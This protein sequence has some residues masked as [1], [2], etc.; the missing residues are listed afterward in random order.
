MRYYPVLSVGYP[1]GEG[2][3]FRHKTASFNSFEEAME[4]AEGE[5]AR[6]KTG[7]E[8]EKGEEIPEGMILPGAEVDT[9]LSF[10]EN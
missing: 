9:A 6:I 3:I 1:E 8:E 5:V 7:F 10:S 2:T 4:F